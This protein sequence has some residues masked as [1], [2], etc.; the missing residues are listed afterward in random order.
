MAWAYFQNQAAWNTYHN[1]VCAA[2]GIPKA[3]RN[4]ASNEPAI[5]E[6]WTDAFIAPIQIKS[7][8]NVTTWAAQIPDAHVTQYDPQLGIT[9]PD[10]AVTFS[11]ANVTP[12]TVTIAAGNPGAGTYTLQPNTLTYKKAKPPTVA[13]DGITYDTATGEPIP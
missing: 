13:M 10:S 6:C 2:E 5:M 4:A 11:P 9:V 1:A 7:Q 3:G 8:G 12:S